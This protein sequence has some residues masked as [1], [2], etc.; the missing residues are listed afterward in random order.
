M[1]ILVDIC[2]MPN[3]NLFLL[4]KFYG[5]NNVIKRGLVGVIPEVN[6]AHVMKSLPIV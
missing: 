6:I 5:S 4:V 1:I 3:F 2:E